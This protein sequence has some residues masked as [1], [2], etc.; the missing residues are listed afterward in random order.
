MYEKIN[1]LK[2]ILLLEL[3]KN[4]GFNSKSEF[5]YAFMYLDTEL[6]RQLPN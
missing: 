3:I 2:Y 4:I 1:I 5:V 6:Q